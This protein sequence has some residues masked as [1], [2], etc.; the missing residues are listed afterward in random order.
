VSLEDV[1]VLEIDTQLALQRTSS[2]TWKSVVPDVELDLGLLPGV[3]LDLDFTYA[4]EGP[5]SGRLG[6]SSAAPDNVW[7]AGK[8]GL[9]NVHDDVTKRA[10]SVVAQAGPRIPTAPGTRGLGAE[11]LLLL[12]R[13]WPGQHAVLNLGAAV[14]PRAPSDARK[15][16][17]F[18]GGLDVD[19]DLDAAHR[20]SF[21]CEIGAW[22]ALTDHAHQLHATAGIGWS[23]SASLTLS[24]VALVGFLRD[25]D[26]YGILFGV[27]PKWALWK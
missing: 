23:P 10:W 14:D 22:Y 8:F 20:F 25:G 5:S 3:E 13:T 24:A 16:Y 12:G 9:F 19:V 4:V 21:L 17:G 15:P 1:G 2:S 18:E 27:S 26:R 11:A 7:S 6:F